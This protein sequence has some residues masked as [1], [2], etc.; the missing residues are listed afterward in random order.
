MTYSTESKVTLYRIVIK[1]KHITI[2]GKI[3]VCGNFEIQN[4]KKHALP[5][6]NVFL[7]RESSPEK[8]YGK[9][10]SPNL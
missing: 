9:S 2:K 5:K 7:L 10:P 6:C 8:E 4:T 1:E 3:T